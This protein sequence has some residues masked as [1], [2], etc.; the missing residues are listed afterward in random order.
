MTTTPVMQAISDLRISMLQQKKEVSRAQAV[1]AALE[2]IHAAGSGGG[3][4]FDLEG[5]MLR[6]SKY[7]DLIQEAMT[8]K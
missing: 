2:L 6:L 8:I 7:A 5:E 4:R 1:A 3:D